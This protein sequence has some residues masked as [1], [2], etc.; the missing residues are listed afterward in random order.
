MLLIGIFHR[1]DKVERGLVLD[2]VLGDSRD[3]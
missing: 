1:L 3:H 2:G